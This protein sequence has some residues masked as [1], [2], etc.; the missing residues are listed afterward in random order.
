[1]DWVA[2][3][4]EEFHSGTVRYF[5]KIPVYRYFSVRYKPY[6]FIPGFFENC[7]VFF[8]ISLLVQ[9]VINLEIFHN[10]L[11]KQPKKHFFVITIKL[12]N[13]IKESEIIFGG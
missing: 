6:I 9:L 10:C 4:Y 3:R 5:C 2:V 1:M 7:S 12:K 11:S 8:G 13:I